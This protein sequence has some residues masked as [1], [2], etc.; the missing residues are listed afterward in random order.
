MPGMRLFW[1]INL[2][3]ELK[4]K[5]YATVKYPLD[6]FPVNMKWVEEQNIHLTLKF[7]GD[8]EVHR[9]ERLVKAVEEEVR[10]LGPMHF[11]VSGIG[12]FPGHRRPC[13][14]WAGLGGQVKELRVLQG[15]LEKVHASL[16]FEPE[17]RGFSPHITLARF[18]SPEGSAGFVRRAEESIPSTGQIGSFTVASVDLMQSIL[19][20]K[21]PTY[22]ILEQVVL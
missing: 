15:K 8:V 22:H 21:G 10:G 16:G 1:A 3:A 20:P 13:V 7:L 9:V 11:E 14:F 4:K 2:P 5:L 6:S 17:K 12:F 19:S 18:R